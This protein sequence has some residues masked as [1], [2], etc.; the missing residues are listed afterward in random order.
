MDRISGRLALL[1]AVVLV[2]VVVIAAWFAV[3]SPQRSK[4]AALDTQIGDANV[5]LASTEA[6][7]SSPTARQSTVQL[8]QL[9]RALPDDTEMSEIIRE[10]SRAASKTGV[11]VDS[12]TPSTPVAAAGAQALP[13]TLSVS[14]RYFRIA[15]FMHELRTRAKVEDGNVRVKGRLFAVDNVAFAKSP[16]KGLLS[17]T[18]ALDAFMAGA[19][20]AQPSTAVG[21]QTTTTTP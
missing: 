21:A 19:A 4:A 12:I 17:A 14:G 2:L 10:L 6:L 5:R 13:I 1:V 9:R 18:L 16:T 20:P 11:R 7:L 15:N 8:A 3:L